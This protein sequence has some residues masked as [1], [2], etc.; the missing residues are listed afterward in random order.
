MKKLLIYGATGYMGSMVAHQAKAAGLRL[1]G[2]RGETPTSCFRSRRN[3]TFDFAERIP[4]TRI[5][6]KHV[7]AQLPQNE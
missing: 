4:G 2:R 5:V 7:Q 3:S 1:C 6:D